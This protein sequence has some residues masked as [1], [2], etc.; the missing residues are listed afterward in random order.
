[1]VQFNASDSANLLEFLLMLP[2]VENKNVLNAIEL[3]IYPA[4]TKNLAPHAHIS[5]NFI[6]R[7]ALKQYLK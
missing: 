6:P 2:L 5:M 4:L 1:M 3:E 7:V